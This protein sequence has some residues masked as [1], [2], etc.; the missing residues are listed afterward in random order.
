MII[1]L[2]GRKGVGKDTFASHFLSIHP[3]FK[4]VS[5]S[6]KLKDVVSYLFNWDRE[7]IEGKSNRELREIV[8]GN[9]DEE[10]PGITM[11]NMMQKLGSKMNEIDPCFWLK[12][13]KNEFDCENILISDVRHIKQLEYITN[14]Y[15]NVISIKIVN[16]NVEKDGHEDEVDLIDTNFVI[17]NDGSLND[18]LRK[19]ELID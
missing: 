6:S 9:W 17:E 3:N 16:E 4:I 2:V 13:M 12:V 14:K 19:I 5:I 18:F 11:R 10:F 1:A 7:I 15:K 8:D